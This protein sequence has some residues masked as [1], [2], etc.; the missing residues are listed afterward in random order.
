MS[1]RCQGARPRPGTAGDDRRRLLLDGM[2]DR[3][4]ATIRPA[5]TATVRHLT[6]ARL[7]RSESGREGALTRTAGTHPPTG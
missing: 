6:P 5:V 3:A 7:T 4:A 1:T 2:R